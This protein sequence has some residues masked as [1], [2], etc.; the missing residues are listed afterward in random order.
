VMKL[1][2]DQTLIM[3]RVPSLANVIT[4]P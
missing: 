1:A 4:R 2:N 3:I